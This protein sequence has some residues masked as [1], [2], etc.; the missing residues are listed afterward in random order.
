MSRWFTEYG[1]DEVADGLHVGALPRDGDDVAQLAARGVTRVVSLVD[2]PEYGDG[3][4]EAVAA[5][6]AAH[7][8]AEQRVPVTDFGHLLPGHLERAAAL[9]RE[10]REAGDVV[11]LHCRAG[12]QRSVVAAAASLAEQDGLDPLGALRVVMTRRRGADP[13]P[14]QVTDLVRW[15]SARAA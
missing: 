7:G 8:I 1:L 3:E 13:L 14:H 6:Y 11:Y 2:D 9:V 15:W 4:H 12:W 5:A 10:A